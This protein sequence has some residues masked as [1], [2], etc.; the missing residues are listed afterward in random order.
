LFIFSIPG[1]IGWVYRHPEYK[2][3]LLAMVPWFVGFAVAL[4]FIAAIGVG[5]ALVRRQLVPGRRIAQCAA[6][7]IAIVGGLLFVAT[8]FTPLSWYLA[9]GVVA[10]V[11]FVRLGL[12]PL[13]L[14]ENRHR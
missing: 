13:A 10:I 3:S 1:L 6:L 8:L 5:T 2:E 14:A 9:V 11:P 7:W 12:A 4:R